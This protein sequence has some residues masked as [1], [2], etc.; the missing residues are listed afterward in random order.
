MADFKQEKEV[1]LRRN[2][3]C[4][5]GFSII[6]GIGSD[7]PPIVCDILEESPADLCGEVSA[8]SH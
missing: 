6:G 3:S 2:A 1:H 5:F 8:H 7:L 4:G